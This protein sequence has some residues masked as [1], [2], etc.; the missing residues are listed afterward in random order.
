M[1]DQR[2]RF[3]YPYPQNHRIRMYVRKVSTDICFRLW[4]ADDATLWD[5]H[6]WVPVTAI[7]QAIALYRGKGFD[8]ADAYDIRVATA[9]LSEDR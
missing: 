1:E 2:G 3:Y 4:D 8:P 6:G 9:V 5:T 7:Q